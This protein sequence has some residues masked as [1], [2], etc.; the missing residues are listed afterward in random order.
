M[1]DREN[2]VIQAVKSAL[3]TDY[4]DM[5]VYSITTL[6]PETFPCACV[7]M[8]D[9]YTLKEARTTSNIENMAQVMF[10][11]N[12]Y[13]NKAKGKKAEAKAIFNIIDETLTGLFFTREYTRP[14][15]I[16]NGTAYRY[17]GRYKGLI[18]K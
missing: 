14:V 10:E 17:V 12:V 1:I 9:N 8:M 2:E 7:E 4:P 6:A 3:A 15:N 18:S 16:D 13:S 5:P 11:V